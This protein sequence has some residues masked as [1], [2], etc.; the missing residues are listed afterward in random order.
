V[1]RFYIETQGCQMNKADTE[2]ISGML[3]HE[4]WIAVQAPEEADLI[5]VNGC[6]VREK[7]ENRAVQR[8]RS[9]NR[10]G[11]KVKVGLIG[12]AAEWIGDSVRDLLPD[13]YL[14]ASPARFH[15]LPRLAVH[16]GYAMGSSEWEPEDTNPDRG[17]GIRAWI[18]IMRGCDQWCSY[19]VVPTTRGKQISFPAEYVIGKAT[20]AL[21]RGYVELVL[22][23]QRVSAYRHEDLDFLD[24]IAG[25]EKIPGVKRIRF[26]APYP[27]DISEPLLR[28]MGSSDIVEHRLHLPL[29]SGSNRI[30]TRMNRG[31]SMEQYRDLIAAARKHIPDLALSTDLIVGFPG[32]L[33]RDFEDTVSA[34]K[35]F[36]FD[37]AFTFA[38]SERKGTSAA[39]MDGK[40]AP[41]VQRDRLKRLID[42]H[43]EVLG[44]QRSGFIGR[45]VK[46]IV[47]GADTKEPNYSLGKTSGGIVVILPGEYAI[48]SEVVVTI[49]GL[50]GHTLVG[51]PLI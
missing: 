20:D 9:F 22:L 29:Q 7:A 35:E 37:T 18:P 42:V 16:G 1:R 13:I 48:G 34:V 28:F 31:Y 2:R 45:R 26:T 51:S 33:E 4:G 3:V 15:E 27:S 50:R 39:D 43:H 38:Y 36:K 32:E 14:A 17:T 12:C 44:R 11:E 6:A 5:L 23:G 8:A 25:I 49:N 10:I 24:L 21:N 19:C 41:A 47:E 46:I 30:L 40:V